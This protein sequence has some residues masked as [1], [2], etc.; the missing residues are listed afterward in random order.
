MPPTHLASIAFSNPAAMT[1]L[2][3]PTAGVAARDFNQRLLNSRQTHL[4]T[5]SLQQRR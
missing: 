3:S 4:E 5:R 1:V 2:A